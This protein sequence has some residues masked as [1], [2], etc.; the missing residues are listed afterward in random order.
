[1]ITLIATEREEDRTRTVYIPP[2]NL[3]YVI[4]DPFRHSH[5]HTL[6][7]F[8]SYFCLH[9]ATD[10]TPTPGFSSL[11]AFHISRCLFPETTQNHGFRNMA[12]DILTSRVT[13]ATATH[14]HFPRSLAIS[15]LDL[16]EDRFPLIS[17]SHHVLQPIQQLPPPS[18]NIISPSTSFYPNAVHQAVRGPSLLSSDLP[19]HS[20]N[21]S[22]AS[23]RSPSPQPEFPTI[24]DERR[25]V[26]HP[27]SSSTPLDA[28]SPNSYPL[29]HVQP[30]NSPPS[31]DEINMQLFGPSQ[32]S[33][34][35][36][37]DTGKPSPTGDIRLS[38]RPPRPVQLVPQRR[39]SP[40]RSQSPELYSP[41]PRSVVA[42]SQGQAMPLPGSPLSQGM[43]ISTMAQYNQAIPVTVSPVPRVQAQQP[44]YIT[45]TM[46]PNPIKPVFTT[47]PEEICVECAMRDQD[48][49]DVD[50]ASP[51][52]WARDS[53]V[54]FED[55][56]RRELDEES[57]GI[58][59]QDPQRPRARGGWL[60]EANL[61]L[62]L[63][64]VRLFFSSQ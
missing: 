17:Q 49:A 28:D 27:D 42:A 52:I 29:G 59:P 48:M 22:P 35:S 61:K 60:T 10:S 30:S 13:P 6:P 1:M 24:H 18:V 63:S 23:L 56:L 46:A 26:H 41:S 57:M 9:Y 45:P 25:P 53:D 37:G 3:F 33:Q 40:Q 50:V 21:M 62:W 11:S 34:A 51:G 43:R 38:S 8:P 7:P 19:S 4:P 55:L 47:R 12:T 5:T 20:M 31:Q 14:R 54:Y 39:T 2:W 16:R 36:S 32:T 64:L 44:T 15:D 58:P